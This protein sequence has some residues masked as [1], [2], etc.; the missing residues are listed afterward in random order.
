MHKSR[1]EA[2]IDK[3]RR[4]EEALNEAMSRQS[5]LLDTEVIVNG[6]T[7]LKPHKQIVCLIGQDAYPL[8]N[9]ISKQNQKI[10]K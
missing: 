7:Y 6:H 9:F 3:K 2:M 5:E 8:T 10:K 1:N 4:L